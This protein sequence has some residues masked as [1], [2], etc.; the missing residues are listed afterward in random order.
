MPR[1]G[2]TTSG[3]SLDSLTTWLRGSFGRGAPRRLIEVVAL[4]VEDMVR[5]SF[6]ASATPEGESWAPLKRPRLG[7]RALVKTG[8]LRRMATTVRRTSRGVSIVLRG[9]PVAQLRGTKHIPA[10]AFLPRLPLTPALQ[11]VIEDALQ[12]SIGAP[13]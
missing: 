13:R 3:D 6:T 2:V 8:R 12:R 10:R 4:E 9:Y 1:A 7:G 11:R 5:G